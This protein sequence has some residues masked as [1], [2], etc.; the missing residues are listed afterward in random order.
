MARTITVDTGLEL[1]AFI[2]G[3]IEAGRYKNHRDLVCEGLRLLQE[4]HSTSS[5][6]TLRQ[7]IAEGESSGDAADWAVYDFLERMQQACMEAN[8]GS[9]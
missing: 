5:T 4:K 9:E 2:Q 3:Q 7:L 1:R 8:H 6:E